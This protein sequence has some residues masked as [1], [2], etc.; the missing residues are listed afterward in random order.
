MPSVAVIP[1]FDPREDLCFSLLVVDKAVLVY[2]FNLHGFEEAFGYRIV[3]AVAFSTRASDDIPV[4][5][6]LT[7]FIASILYSP[8]GVED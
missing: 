8:I 3:P 6:E 2:Q 5:Q 1:S 4:Y 7:K